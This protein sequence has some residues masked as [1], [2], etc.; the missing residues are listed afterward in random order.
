MATGVSTRLVLAVLSIWFEGL[1]IS[2]WPS[3]PPEIGGSV[4]NTQKSKNGM[5]TPSSAATAFGSDTFLATTGLPTEAQGAV[6]SVA[7]AVVRSATTTLANPANVMI[8]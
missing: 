6:A 2:L 1:S 3:S 7:C 5:S 8:V 4:W